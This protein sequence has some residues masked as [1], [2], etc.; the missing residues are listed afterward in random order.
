MTLSV[1]FILNS[2]ADEN[3][4]KIGMLIPMTGDD[5]KIGQQIIKA[6]RMALRDI[7]SPNIEIFPKDTGSNPN[8][9]LDAANEFDQMG[10]RIVIGPIF[11]KNI[12]HLD[13][14]K[15]IKPTIV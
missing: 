8:Q 15:N 7:G 10:I 5:K 13:K 14:V 3:K 9:T 12:I 6:T 11:Y 1:C 4:L 2:Y